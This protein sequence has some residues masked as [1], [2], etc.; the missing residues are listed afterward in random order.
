[1]VLRGFPSGPLAGRRLR[2]DPV[3]DVWSWPKVV[4]LSPIMGVPNSKRAFSPF[5][6][7]S[8]AISSPPSLNFP[9]FVRG[10]VLFQLSWPASASFF[11]QDRSF[12]TRLRHPRP[13]LKV[14][15]GTTSGPPTGTPNLP[16]GHKYSSL[17]A[18]GFLSF[19]PAPG[20]EKCPPTA[21]PAPFS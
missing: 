17:E 12:S 8:R 2:F 6:T 20:V 5:S 21:A 9:A 10:G 7:P 16:D 15:Q 3:Q 1:M 18:F 11:S 13:H 14:F 19:L 4:V